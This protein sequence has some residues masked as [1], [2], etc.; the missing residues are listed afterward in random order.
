MIILFMKKL[1]TDTSAEEISRIKSILVRNNIKFEMKLTHGRFGGSQDSHVYVKSMPVVNTAPEPM[2]IYSI[3]VNRKDHA[4][5]R[6][7]VWGS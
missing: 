4:H 3:Y 6:K 7:L 5:A 1:A 2:V